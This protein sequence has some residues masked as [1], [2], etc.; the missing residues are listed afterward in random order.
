MPTNV[1]NKIKLPNADVYDIQDAN[2]LPKTTTIN[3][4]SKAQDAN[5]YTLTGDDIKL[6]GS[7]VVPQT[8]TPPVAGVTSVEDSIANLVKHVD[9]VVSGGV[10]SVDEAPTS[11]L[12]ITTT[13]GAVTVDVAQGY[14]IPPSTVQTP[15]S[16]GSTVSLVSTGDMYTW[17]NKQSSIKVGSSAV[18][19][20]NH[21]TTFAE[22]ANV[23]ITAENGTI[24][25]AATDT[26]YSTFDATHAGLAPA[27]GTTAGFLKNDGSW[28]IPDNT[29]YTV[30]TGTVNGKIKVTPSNDTAYEVPVYGLNNAAYKDV[31]LSITA[32]STSTKLPTSQAVATFVEGKG[33]TTNTGTVTQ[34]GA[35]GGLKTNKTNNAD[36][37]DSGTLE[38][39][40]KDTAYSTAV[41]NKKTTTQIYP[42]V[43]DSVGYPC[44]GVPWT[45][46]TYT[47]AS[48]SAIT[49]NNT[50]HTIDVAVGAVGTKGVVELSTSIPAVG[51]AVDTKVAT[52]KAVAS[53]IDA[54]PE[55]MIFKGSVGDS[56]TVT[57][58]NLPSA[59]S[60]NE[61]Y[62]YKVITKHTTTPKCEVGDTIISN[63]SEWVVIPSGDEPK[64]DVTG[65][66]LGT[67]GST[68]SPGSD[69]VVELP[70]YPTSMSID[71]ISGI[72]TNTS[73]K[74]V[75][76]INNRVDTLSTS[77]A[78]S[79][80]PSGNY[81][82]QFSYD[83]TTAKLTINYLTYTKAASVTTTQVNNVVT[84]TS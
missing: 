47:Q 77:A 19:D 29:T 34:I 17:D 28:A 42:V 7:Y 80:A 75:N 78:S 45:D 64:G 71:N 22:G 58:T 40:L 70:A 65:I 63:G 59:A 20:A 48:N 10:T 1:I 11:H 6:S 36:I 32:S 57:W 26:T 56:G 21:V 66:K 35:T 23:D 39:N 62:T 72:A 51:S 54:L 52:E 8:Y 30:E 83:S 31:D 49:V 4:V 9:D 76:A 41:G 44:V 79:T 61:G 82:N 2:A 18:A 38:L 13:D 43:L 33:Y 27:G 68:Y 16:G 55:P 37:T 14:V 50:N 73:I 12:N 69:G 81:V 67:G 3:G 74:G 53:A 15:A 5:T 46:T 24:T 25:I 84:K 60:S